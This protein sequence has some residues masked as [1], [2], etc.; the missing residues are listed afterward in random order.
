MVRAQETG[1][2]PSNLVPWPAYNTTE[3]GGGATC[4]E[5][6][7]EAIVDPFQRIMR[8]NSLALMAF[9]KRS[10]GKAEFSRAEL[11]ALDKERQ[12]GECE[13]VFRQDGDKLV[14][15]LDDSEKYW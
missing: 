1:T 6:N 15:F 9:L 3:T 5:N 11:E 14:V 12:T 13:L 2:P 4:Q 7:M 10:G 8:W